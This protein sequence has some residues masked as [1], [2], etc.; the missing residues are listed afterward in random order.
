MKK[1]ISTLLII[2]ITVTCIFAFAGCDGNKIE[3]VAID[4]TDLINEDFG[5]AVTKSNTA[6]LEAVNKVIDE[7]VDNGK[8]E[9][10]IDY[11][12]AL[13]NYDKN[14]NGGKAPVV[15]EGLQTKWDFGSATNEITVYTESGFAPYEFILGGK[16][17]IIGV[18]IAIM[19]QVA[20]NL[21]KKLNIQD[22]SF[23]SIPT[24]VQDAK[25]DAVGAAGLSITEERSKIV[26][27]S[28]IY[29]SS[30]MVILTAKDKNLNSV[31]DLAG[32]KVGVQEGT[33]GDLIISDASTSAGYVYE[34]G[35]DDNKEM[36]TVKAAGAETVRYKQYALA[37]ADLKAGRIDAILM[38]KLP[39]LSL[40][41][42]IG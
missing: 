26:N 42:T 27:F 14:E 3:Y 39:A 22:V 30:T 31:A 21:G 24:F 7:W 35:D 34:I 18:D 15:P 17:E 37:F 6:L 20:I 23:D 33:S 10:Y 4:A 19:S 40:I 29:C 1:I 11:Y 36:V 9:Q 32:L 8:M 25:G 41:K 38:D 28:S 16:T 2:A 13:D 12:D 5:I